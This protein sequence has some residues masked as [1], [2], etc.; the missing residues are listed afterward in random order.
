MADHVYEKAKLAW[1]F[2]KGVFVFKP[3]MGLAEGVAAKTLSVTIGVD[4]FDKVDILI[5]E[6]LN[7][8]DKD[9]VDPAINRLWEVINPYLGDGDNIVQTFVGLKRKKIP[10]AAEETKVEST[11]PPSRPLKCPH[12]NITPQSDT[13]TPPPDTTT[14]PPATVSNVNPPLDTITPPP[15]TVCNINPPSDEIIAPSDTITPPSATLGN[16]NPPSPKIIAESDMFTP[17][18][19]TLCNTNPPSVEVI[20]SPERI[21]P[22]RK[23]IIPTSD[24]DK[25]TPL[26]EMITPTSDNITPSSSH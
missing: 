13:I 14:P 8:L 2:G 23:K 9:F 26:S 3:F 7:Y 11:T 4:D 20:P 15:A 10:S 19:E 18:P 25:I 17:P 12:F 6:R 21:T 16:I 22:P 1:S 24:T 5:R